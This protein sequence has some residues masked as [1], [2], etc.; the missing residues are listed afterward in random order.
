MEEAF[1]LWMGV[2]GLEAKDGR[3]GG[4]E[5]EFVEGFVFGH[6]LRVLRGPRF[7]PRFLVFCDGRRGCAV[8]FVFF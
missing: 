3:E 5:R 6:G 8:T 7:S 2:Y 4:W 1:F